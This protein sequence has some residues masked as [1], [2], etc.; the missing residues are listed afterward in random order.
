MERRPAQALL[1]YRLVEKIGEGGMGEVWRATDTTL[2][3]DVALKFLPP[4]LASDPE[5]LARFERE[6]KVLASLNHPGIAAIYGLHEHAGV[7]FLA[8][9][10]VPG[11]DLAQ[12][13][14]AGPLPVAETT[15]VARQIAEAVEAA[16]DQG[17]IHRDLKPANVKLTPE[18][19]V[20]V[21]DFGLAKALDPGASGVPG[22]DSRMSPTVTS[23]GTVAGLILGTAAYMSP[24]QAKGKPIDRRTD[25]WAFGCIVYEMLAGRRPFEGEGISEVLAAV[26]MAP[27]AFDAL[28]PSLPAQLRNL[29]RRC[30]ERDPRKRLRDI[31]EARLVLEEIQTGGPEPSMAA[32]TPPA[33]PRRLAP[34]I[35]ATAFLAAL[36]ALGVQRFLA[37]PPP[38][39][40]LRRF[41]VPAPGPFRSVNQ[42]RLIGISPDGKAIAS[43]QGGKILVRPLDRLEPTVISPAADPSLLFWSP[44]S[45][46]LGYA[47]GGK[48]WKVAAGGGEASVVADVRAPLTGGTSATWCPNGKIVFGTGDGGLKSVPAAGGEISEIVP[49]DEK[50]E[51]DLHDATCLPDDSLLFVP[52]SV[53]GRPN[54]LWIQAKGKRT[55]L[56]ALASDQDIWFPV[57]SPAGYILYHRHPTNAGVWALP[58]SLARHQ[59]TGDPFLVATGADVP[60]VSADGTLVHVEGSN[61]RAGRL[62]WVDRSGRAVAAVGPPQESWPFP[63]LSPDGRF[64]AVDAKENDLSDVWVLDVERGTRTRL[65][66]AGTGYSLQAWSPDGRTL[67]YSSG[68]APP[69][70][71]K[72][73]D[74][75]GGGE[76]RT[77]RTGWSPSYSADGRF[78]LFADYARGSLWD[79]WYQDLRAGGPA[80]PLLR[81]QA[82]EVA[83]RLSP[84]GRYVAYVSDES[85]PD[86]VYLKR[87]PGG[88]GRWQV[89]TGGGDWPR[90]D[91]QG[92][93]LYYVVGDAMMEVDIALGAEP[94]LGAPRELFKRTSLGR[95]LPFGWPPGYDVS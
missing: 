15:D 3:R 52:H 37:S 14:G 6:A 16:H 29:V 9:E 93:K 79:V 77:L 55:Q 24:E 42:S 33:R 48:L 2:A 45:A 62:T 36:G 19:K 22:S 31:G 47:A 7:R 64:V 90:F 76:E 80:V 60:S 1:H 58:F 8:M 18:G 72:A 51:T 78:L 41:T 91:R 50:K 38:A 25:I 88:E 49:V 82:S 34:V 43:V 21:L 32:G 84:D 5:R 10:L 59:A 35:A 27:I 17:I 85:G 56:L 4:A 83:P 86:E 95:A 12:R 73:K 13:L 65:S 89:S 92:T 94:R 53:N 67:L 71:L 30:L 75:D 63:E 69:L 23:L 44:D 81:S 87:F 20:K 26:I 40:P 11:Q 39:P 68:A 57:Y 54:A 46:F 74:A 66:A 28:P 70:T 61:S